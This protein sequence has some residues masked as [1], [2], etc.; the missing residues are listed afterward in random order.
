MEWADTI[1]FS[2]GFITAICAVL[3]M[4]YDRVLHPSSPE[5]WCISLMLIGF[6][7][8]GGFL[9]TVFSLLYY[10]MNYLYYKER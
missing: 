1:W 4:A 7:T 10:A 8:V 5:D 9:T 2:V 3:R 6:G